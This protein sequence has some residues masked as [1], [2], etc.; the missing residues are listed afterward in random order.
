MSRGNICRALYKNQ[1]WLYRVQIFFLNITNSLSFVKSFCVLHVNLEIL[2]LKEVLLTKGI[3]KGQK[4][5]Y[6]F[7]CYINLR[8]SHPANQTATVLFLACRHKP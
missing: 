6:Y 4:M 3:E 5:A 8:P 1:V 2:W 7:S